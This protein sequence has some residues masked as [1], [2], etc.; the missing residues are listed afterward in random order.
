M[1]FAS[2]RGS[3]VEAL[4]RSIG[5]LHIP[6]RIVLVISNNSGAGALKIARNADIPTLHIS[7][8]QYESHERF[9]Q[10]L[11]D[12]LSAVHTDLIVLAGYMKKLPSEICRKYPGRILNIHPALL[13]AFGG[14]GMYGLYVHEAVI[15]SGAQVSGATVHIVNDEYDRGKIIMQENVPVLHDDTPETLA[16]RVLDAEHRILPRAVADIVEQIQKDSHKKLV[17]E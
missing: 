12:A 11:L 5:A 9:T 3:N 14:K 16:A 15:A 17:H 1:C 4:I 10:A 6:A 13:P 8:K 7:E 2:G